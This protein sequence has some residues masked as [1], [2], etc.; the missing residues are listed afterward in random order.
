M[1]RLEW[2][3]VCHL[4]RRRRAKKSPLWLRERGLA[5]RERRKEKRKTSLP[6]EYL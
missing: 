1:G 4:V 3:V 5:Y 6:F 2:R